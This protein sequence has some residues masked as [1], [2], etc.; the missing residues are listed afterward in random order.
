[1]ERLRISATNLALIVSSG[2]ECV[3]YWLTALRTKPAQ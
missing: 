3:Q 1:M 2:E